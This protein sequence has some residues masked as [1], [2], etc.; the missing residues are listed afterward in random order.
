MWWFL[1]LS[2]F[3]EW[4]ENAARES[5]SQVIVFAFTCEQPFLAAGCKGEKCFKKRSNI[6]YVKFREA[7]V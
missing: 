6:E 2:S 3:S 7:S 4:Q 5:F 1:T